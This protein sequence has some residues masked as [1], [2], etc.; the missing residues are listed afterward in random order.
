M[1]YL[2]D[3]DADGLRHGH[4]RQWMH[5][6]LVYDGEWSRG[7]RDGTGS[8]HR[9]GNLAY[10]GGWLRGKRNGRGV[11]YYSDGEVEYEGEWEEDE[12]SGEGRFRE[13]DGSTVYEGSWCAGM[14]DGFGVQRWSGGERYVGQWFLDLHEGEG[15]YYDVD[16]TPLYTGQWHVHKRHG[17]GEEFGFAWSYKG[18]WRRDERNGHGVFSRRGVLEY[19]GEWKDGVRDGRGTK[20]WPDGTVEHVGYWTAGR[21]D[22][23]R[24]RREATRD[25]ILALHDRSASDGAVGQVPTCAICLTELHHGDVTYVYVPCGHRVLCGTCGTSDEWSRQCVV[26]KRVAWRMRVF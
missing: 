6:F 5:G 12:Q 25:R 17:V 4:G 2:G 8:E 7:V 15:T 26:C 23:V 18:E 20:F 9:H 3:R 19:E 10:T 24:K 13:R 11:S 22:P 14:R 21:K 1:P 16:G